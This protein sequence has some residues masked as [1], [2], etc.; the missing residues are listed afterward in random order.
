MFES[1]LVGFWRKQV[2]SDFI[3][4]QGEDDVNLM[5]SEWKPQSLSLAHLQSAFGAMLLGNI[6]ALLALV[7]EI[8]LGNRRW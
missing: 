2:I 5:E 1:G 3:R 6:L 7:L 4:S 8:S